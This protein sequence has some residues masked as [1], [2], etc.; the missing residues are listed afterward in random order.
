MTLK[1]KNILLALFFLALSFSYP[2]EE[3]A[4]ADDRCEGQWKQTSVSAEQE[5]L[6]LEMSDDDDDNDPEREE[7]VIERL[8]SGEPI[9]FGGFSFG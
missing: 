7:E 1:I 8:A 5:C 2:D 6:L 4:A 3:V 9:R